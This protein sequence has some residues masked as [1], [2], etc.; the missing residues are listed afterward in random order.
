[1]SHVS[2]SRDVKSHDGP[3]YVNDLFVW[4]MISVMLKP[5]EVLLRWNQIPIVYRLCVYDKL[6]DL[7]IRY[8]DAQ[9]EGKKKVHL[10]PSGASDRVLYVFHHKLIMKYIYLSFPYFSF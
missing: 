8:R 5:S 6:F 4:F 10:C 3:G 2:F 7:C 1:M 9:I